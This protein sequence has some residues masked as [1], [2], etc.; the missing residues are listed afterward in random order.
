VCRTRAIQ[1]TNATEADEWEEKTVA[2][3][4]ECAY[5]NSF[6][7]SRLGFGQNLRMVK[8]PA[9]FDADMCTRNLKTVFLYMLGKA[10]FDNKEQFDTVIEFSTEAVKKYIGER[11]LMRYPRNVTYFEG[12]RQLLFH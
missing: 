12:M 6:K 9:V 7:P 2:L 1:S 10:S 8:I 11:E 4:F 3:F 5:V